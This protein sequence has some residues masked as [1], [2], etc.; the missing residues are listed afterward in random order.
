M[1]LKKFLSVFLAL[2]MLLSCGLPVFATTDPDDTL[3]YSGFDVFYTTDPVP[4]PPTDGFAVT[5]GTVDWDPENTITLGLVGKT[6][7]SVQPFEA[8]VYTVNVGDKVEIDVSAL[9]VDLWNGEYEFSY[10][11]YDACV[12]TYKSA[13]ADDEDPYY[14][15]CYNLY[16]NVW[17]ETNGER[18]VTLSEELD[19]ETLK[20]FLNA[21]AAGCANIRLGGE[22][23]SLLVK[24]V[25]N[26]VAQI[27]GGAKYTSFEAAVAA[28]QAGDTIELLADVSVNTGS[29]SSSRYPISKS[30][31]IDGNDHTITINNRGFGVGMNA[32]SDVDVTFKDV[33]ITNPS[34]GGRCVDTRGHISSLTLD[35]AVLVTTGTSGYLQPLTIGGNQ[36]TAAEVVIKDSTIKTSEDG[37]KGYAIITFNPVNMT[38]TDSTLKGWA[39]VYPKGPDGSAGS[40][41]SVFEI[42]GSELITKNIYPG[43]T[44]DFSLIKAEDNDITVN[45]TD[46]DITVD[47]LKNGQAILSVDAN[48]VENVI[49][50]LGEGNNVELLN[51]GTFVSNGEEDVTV[52]I[53]GGIFN[54]DPSAYVTAGCEAV[55]LTG[56]DE[57]KWQVVDHNV[58]QVGE[59]KYTTLEAAVEAAQSGDTIELL[60]DIDYSTVYTERNARDEGRGHVVDLRDLTL[61]LNGHTIWT[62]NA[63]VTFG[64]NGATI[65]NGTFDLVE[66]NTDGSY[67]DGSYALIIDNAVL[68]Y[69]A[70]GTVDVKDVVIDGGLNVSGAD[71]TIDNVSAHT[72]TTKFYSVWAEEGAKITVN[73]G[74]YADTVNKG[75]GVFHTDGNALII[76]NGGTFTVGNSVKYGAN[77]GTVVLYGGVYTKNP[78]AYV[79]AGCEAVA[80]TGE[81]EG[82]WQVVDHNVAQVGET[83]Y[84]TLEAAVEAAQSGDTI[85]LLADIDYST[86]YTER[87]ARDEGRGHVVDLRDL[88][89]DLNGHTIWTIN[90]TVTFGGNGATIKNGTFDLVEKNTDGSYKDGSYALIIDNA[91]LSYGAAGTVDVKD[92]VI[93]GGLNVSG[94]DVTIDNVSAHTTT[95]KFYSVW[96]EEGAKITVN[97]GEYA[98]TV[99]KGKGVFHTDGNALIIVNGGTFTVGNSVK[100]G[101][102]DGT[103]VLYGG[104]YTKNPTAYVA[105]GYEAVVTGESEWTVGEVKASDLAEAAVAAEGF[106]A[107]YT[108]TKKVVDGDTVLFEGTP[109]TVNVKAVNAGED[110]AASD[111]AVESVK[112]EEVLDSVIAAVGDAADNI[113]VEIQIVRDAPVEIVNDTITYEVHPVAKVYV[114]DALAETVDIDNEALADDASFTVT[115]PVPDEIADKAVNGHIKVTHKSEGYDDEIKTYSLKGEAG[116]YY[117]Q[118]TVTHFSEFELALDGTGSALFTGHTITLNGY[119]DLNFYLNVTED[120]VIAG[121]GTVVNFTWSNTGASYKL[122]TGDF[123]PGRGYRASVKIPAAEMNYSVHAVVT[124]DGA[125]QGETDYYSVRQYAVAILASTSNTE[126]ATL[127][128]TMLDY[129]AKAQDAF[130]RTNVPYANEGVD[131]TMGEV[132]TYMIDA[133]IAAANG[134]ETADNMVD[135]GYQIGG[136]YYTSS[137]VYLSGCTLRH[138]FKGALDAAQFTGVKSGYYYYI[139][140]ENI[141]AAELDAL[142]TFTVG[143]V[144]FKYSALDFA[145]AIIG[146]YSAGNVNYNLAAAT[147]WYNQAANA[148]FG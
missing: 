142:Q 9:V 32:A 68:S 111:T 53:S 134:G 28:A 72:T 45:I 109:V 33:T 96:A 3:T 23:S 87:N 104:V 130:G 65:K 41:G 81:D 78:T 88:T 129:G 7:T 69:G 22:S 4:V 11:N 26:S 43:E 24:V 35:N 77:D 121:E 108:A 132:T 56:E 5:A 61:D 55:A 70:A 100:Y 131:Y 135:V 95:T 62:I 147:Y 54:V 105:A 29:S 36:A 38:I 71:V 144:T 146:A 59:T 76:V 140:V 118:F 15:E 66:K 139:D 12:E 58:A 57:G 112:I 48:T 102:N 91:V 73:S 21:E 114:N 113:D 148:Y 120:Q 74:E 89:L 133:A 49:V 128:K 106:D 67:K 30:L 19:G 46:T 119:I 138:Y 60:A 145:R 31:T 18:P 42:T 63:T 6:P 90:A 93:D 50:N 13:L 103:V 124:I 141:A 20:I 136:T 47:G 122:K 39:C 107:T 1:K 125:V 10:D 79:A 17:A 86:V 85:E 75:K 110:N 16:W 25:D 127:I 117:V 2:A 143:E 51:E 83:K 101:A 84:T 116:A 80:L 82:K 8:P 64:G 14:W 126:L 115:L 94:A 52:R 37:S 34:N 137:L 97:S 92:V 98:D 27:V 44:N 99:N 40:A 123:V